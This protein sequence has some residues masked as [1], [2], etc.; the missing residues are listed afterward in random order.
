MNETVA[1]RTVATGTIAEATTFDDR[2]VI[3]PA[4]LPRVDIP[5]G[6][7]DLVGQFARS[8]GDP[9]AWSGG[10]HDPPAQSRTW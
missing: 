10:R 6:G 3:V 1:D 9:V 7:V 5:V 2:A 4:T 8:I